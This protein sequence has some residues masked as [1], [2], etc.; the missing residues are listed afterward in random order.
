[1]YD[2]NNK[3]YFKISY[4]FNYYVYVLT[5]GCIETPIALLIKCPVLFGSR[6]TSK[7]YY[8]AILLNK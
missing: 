7:H 8:I 2:V 6:Y 4:Y 5:P 1:M 3:I